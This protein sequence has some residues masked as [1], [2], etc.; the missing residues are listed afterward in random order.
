MLEAL[1]WIAAAIA[2]LFLAFWV[3]VLAWP[4]MLCWYLGYPAI[5]VLAE[6]IYLVSLR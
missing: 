3:I 5:G 6:V 2:A 1:I 4:L